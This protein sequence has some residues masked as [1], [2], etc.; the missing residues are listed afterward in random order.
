VIAAIA[1]SAPDRRPMK[2]AAPEPEGAAALAEQ[3]A[4]QRRA[5]D[6]HPNPAHP[7][8]DRSAMQDEGCLTK[9][10]QTE[11]RPCVYGDPGSE[12]TVVLFGDSLAVQYFPAL[13]LLAKA[14][15][16]RL[17][18][19]T[20][21]GCP[22]IAAAVHNHRLEREYRE[23]AVWREHAL[24]RIEREERPELVLVGGRLSTPAMRDGRRLPPNAGRPVLER[25][26]V[27][28]LERLRA[29]GARV[30]VI[31]NLP[32]SPHNI[33]DCVARSLD[34]LDECA[35]ALTAG[36]VEAF[37]RDAAARAGVRLIDLTRVVCP[38][39]LCRAVIGDAIV[40]RDYDHM[41]PTFVRTLAP[42]FERRLPG[43]D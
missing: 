12:T 21:A 19:L 37:D 35:F 15:G 6:L 39:G 23:C 24:R 9:L 20:K 30:A 3:P 13:E 26:Y 31:K 42:R 25:G 29:T 8:R 22:P 33:P 14:H 40:F 2:L 28:V 41:R 5:I 11:S 16:W 27:E 32:R 4:P 34:R 36:N 18:G 43:I 17:V 38:D 7:E 1:L 10:E